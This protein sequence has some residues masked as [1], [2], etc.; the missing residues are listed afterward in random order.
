MLD[1]AGYRPNVGM[2][3]VNS[4][5]QVFWGKR[6]GEASWQFPQG[7]MSTGEELED[8]LF[9]ELY[10]E[11]GLTRNLVSIIAHTKSWLYYDVP[12]KYNKNSKSNYRGQK[13][14]WFLL[15]FLGKDHEIN[16]RSSAVQEFDAWCWTN[17]WDTKDLVVNF[18]QDVYTKALNELAS[19]IG[20]NNVTQ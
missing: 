8:A 19:H 4:Q 16:L 13:Q 9:R 11:L 17:Y 15:R 6:R 18:K 5:D 1:H 7:G 10:E 20:M 12:G 14:I 2:I 3:L